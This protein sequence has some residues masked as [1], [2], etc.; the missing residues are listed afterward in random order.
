MAKFQEVEHHIP[1]KIDKKKHHAAGFNEEARDSRKAKIGFK[2]YMRQLEE[3]TL[4]Q[5]LYLEDDEQD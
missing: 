3:E 2:N 4:E 1:R 5:E